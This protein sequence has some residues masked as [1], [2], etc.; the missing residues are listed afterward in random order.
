MSPQDAELIRNHCEILKEIVKGAPLDYSIETGLLNDLEAIADLA[1]TRPDE[2]AY[3]LHWKTE[4]L[5]G[6]GIL[7]GEQYQ[8]FLD[9]SNKE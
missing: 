7:S 9:S 5:R 6:E 2:A 4:H 8:K 3:R 1:K